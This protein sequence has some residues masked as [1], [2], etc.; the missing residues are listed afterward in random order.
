MVLFHCHFLRTLINISTHIYKIICNNLRYQFDN[1]STFFFL[2]CVHRVRVFVVT[3]L[4]IPLLLWEILLFCFNV[5]VRLHI[6]DFIGHFIHA[7]SLSLLAFAQSIR[8]IFFLLA[9]HTH[10]H[11]IISLF[12]QI[13]STHLCK[14]LYRRL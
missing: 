11:F 12:R 5:I 7:F 1:C 13:I 4:L 10:K 8:F 14:D 6:K 2:F 9:T 3:L